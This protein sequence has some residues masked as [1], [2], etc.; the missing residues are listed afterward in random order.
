MRK[1]TVTCLS[2]VLIF[3]AALW[4]A[5][6]SSA[7]ASEVELEEVLVEG[8]RPETDT[9]KLRY[10]IDRLVGEF[11]YEGHV[12][13]LGSNG[14]ELDRAEVNGGSSCV[15]FG[16]AAAVQCQINVTWPDLR[17]GDGVPV[18]GGVSSLTP[19]LA[20]Y[21]LELSAK[22]VGYFNVDND[23][24]ATGGKGWLLD[25]TLI[26]RSPCVDFP[27][28]CERVVRVEAPPDARVIR[29]RVDLERDG[30]VEVRYNF[31]WVRLAQETPVEIAAAAVPEPVAAPPVG[32]RAN[33]GVPPDVDAWL[34]RMAGEYRVTP[35]RA[36]RFVRGPDKADGCTEW[37]ADEAVATRG[38]PVEARCQGIGAGPGVRCV[39]HMEW[40]ESGIAPKGSGKN[41]PLFW[42]YGYD[43][44]QRSIAKLQVLPTVSTVG[45]SQLF[46]GQLT[47]GELTQC[48]DQTCKI[49]GHELMAPG[50]EWI[51][52]VGVSQFF[53]D[54][55]QEAAAW[56]MYRVK[57]GTSAE[58]RRVPA[59]RSPRR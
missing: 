24:I 41:T 31:Q 39:V 52:F 51:R 53:D 21:S 46:E 54:P 27:G 19:A 42:L 10:W 36:C 59:N 11:R 55:S 3:V 26:A 15:R 14:T 43:P 47:D 29:M 20:V 40:P 50:G 8:R 33:P 37:R 17:D 56:R 49:R 38:G 23:G 44:V 7:A 35:L 6:I 16:N 32:G 18:P 4:L 9:R 28:K 30:K 57:E 58:P 45:A 12:E 5:D 13:R 48:F 25:D 22:Y 2:T 34:R 1:P